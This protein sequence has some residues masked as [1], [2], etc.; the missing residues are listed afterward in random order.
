MFNN[1]DVGCQGTKLFIRTGYS[2]IFKD[3]KKEKSKY[4]YLSSLNTSQ[5][6]HIHSNVVLFVWL[7]ILT[8]PEIRVLWCHIEASMA[9]AWVQHID[10][11]TLAYHCHRC[12]MDNWH[13]VHNWFCYSSPSYRCILFRTLKWNRCIEGK[14]GTE[15]QEPVTVSIRGYLHV[16]MNKLACIN[17]KSIC[18][19]IMWL[20]EHS[21]I[22]QSLVE[23]V[24]Q[25]YLE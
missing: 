15:S 11:A 2:P 21:I 10:F 20:R 12:K 9:Q 24:L 19:Y 1:A 17:L 18:I 4:E 25:P 3:T 23:S 6:P 7:L 8:L 13:H 5:Q 14:Q 22:Y 16:F